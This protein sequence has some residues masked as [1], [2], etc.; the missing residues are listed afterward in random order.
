MAP[1][2]DNAGGAAAAAVVAAP[3]AEP[4]AV[5]DAAAAAAG[6][7][8]VPVGRGCAAITQQ[9]SITRF[10][11]NSHPTLVHVQPQKLPMEYE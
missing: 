11:H 3:E 9:R 1:V 8:V 2:K 7:A 10:T 5:A 4:V 6:E